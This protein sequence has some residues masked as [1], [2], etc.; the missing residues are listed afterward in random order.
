VPLRPGGGTIVPDYL[1]RDRQLAIEADSVTW[2]EHKL[3]RENDADKQ[4]I[5]EPHGFRVLRI[6]GEQTLLDPRQTLERIRAT[7]VATR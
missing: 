1:W 3:V 6:T 5:L 2:H 7:L 4:A